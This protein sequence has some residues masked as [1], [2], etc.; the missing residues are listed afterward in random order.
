MLVFHAGFS[1]WVF[2][3]N[4]RLDILDMTEVISITGGVAGRG[5]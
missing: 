5:I 4:D 1:G 3:V 2:G